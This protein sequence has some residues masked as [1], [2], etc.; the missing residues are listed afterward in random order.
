M[1]GGGSEVAQ[2]WQYDVAPMGRFLMNI[3]TEDATAAPIAVILNWTGLSP[4]K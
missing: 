4:S 2:G 3:S 1:L